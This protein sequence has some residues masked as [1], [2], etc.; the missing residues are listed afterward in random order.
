MCPAYAKK[1]C[2][3]CKKWAKLVPTSVDAVQ[4]GTGMG[5]VGCVQVSMPRAVCTSKCTK[6]TIKVHSY[7]RD[8][9]MIQIRA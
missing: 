5:F 4:S 1:A 3:E 2:N 9:G 6:S 7:P 8:A